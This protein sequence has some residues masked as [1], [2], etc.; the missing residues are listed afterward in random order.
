MV[1]LLFCLFWTACNNLEDL[2]HNKSS[3]ALMM[4]KNMKFRAHL[5]NTNSLVSIQWYVIELT[6]FLKSIDIVTVS[7]K[8]NI[9][10]S[11]R[12]LDYGHIKS[13]FERKNGWQILSGKDQ[14]GYLQAS[15]EHLTTGNTKGGS[16]SV[17]LTSC[18]TGL[19]S[20]V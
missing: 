12:N 18:L 14:G 9:A 3:S 17:L 2:F 13:I 8:P 5:V 20:A 7:P 19:E 10:M 1:L 4:P 11:C 15:Y 16:I 6:Y